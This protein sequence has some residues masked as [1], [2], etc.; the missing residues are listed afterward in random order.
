MSEFCAKLRASSE[1]GVL[2]D[3]SVRMPGFA[4]KRVTSLQF[5]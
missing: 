1:N 4:T 3:A 5:T 2:A